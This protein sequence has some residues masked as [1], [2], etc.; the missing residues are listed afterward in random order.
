MSYIEFEALNLMSLC[1]KTKH[2]IEEDIKK[3]ADEIIT[4][5]L[6]RHNDLSTHWFFG[7]F[8]RKQTREQIIYKYNHSADWAYIDSEYHEVRHPG[9]NRDWRN[10]GSLFN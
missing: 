3:R 9:Y 7:W 8:Y 10:R 4:D 5:S 6:K 1:E 2:K